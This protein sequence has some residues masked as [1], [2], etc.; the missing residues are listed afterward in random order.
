MP[1]AGKRHPAAMPVHLPKPTEP[2]PVFFGHKE[3]LGQKFMRFPLSLKFAV[4]II[5]LLVFAGLAAP[6]LAPYD[7]LEVDVSRKLQGWSIDH[8]LGTD[9]L[10]RD[11]LSR[12][13]YGTRISVGVTAI[14]LGLVFLLGLLI[15]G[16]AGFLGGRVDA[17]IM[18]VCD[19]F[20]TFPLSVLAVFFVGV[21]GAGLLNVVVAMVL[22]S[23]PWYARMV[24]NVVLSVRARDYVLAAR[25]SGLPQMRILSKHILPS[26]YAQ[27][28]VLTTMDVG[29]TII[30]V[31]GL[32]FLGLG[33]VPP[34]PEWGVMINDAR[35]YIY[36]RPMLV[37]WPGLL[38]FLTVMAFNRVGDALRDR[39]DPGL[40]AGG[41]KR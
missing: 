16:I 3:G 10:G 22:A 40:M 29:N 8:W 37:I 25:A 17:V 32:S 19:V 41:G 1:P 23:W 31:A 35:S 2:S 6:W 34:T 11:M 39:F 4:F 21:L 28:M 38:L 20:M 30:H 7:P 12:L 9:Y 24:R 33:V 15:G 26:V 14:V 13:L 18:R 36:S 27:L 5:A